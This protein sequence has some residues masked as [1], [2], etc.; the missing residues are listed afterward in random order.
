MINQNKYSILVRN[1]EQN[2]LKEAS[3]K[4]GKGI[5][6]FSPLAQGMLTDHY[7][8]GIPAD[9]RAAKDARYLKPEFIT[10]EKVQALRA[11][12]ADCGGTRRDTGPYGTEVGDARRCGDVRAGGASRP[13]QLIGELPCVRRASASRRGGLVA[14]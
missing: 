14:H 10:P 4:N 12:N 6:A 11:L 7:L 13:E 1:I 2:G 5:I 8:N 3:V 9:S